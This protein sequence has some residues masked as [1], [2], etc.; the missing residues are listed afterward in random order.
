MSEEV[1][2]STTGL[3]VPRKLLV[4]DVISGLIMAIVTIPGAIANGVL[5][6][7]N[8]VYGLYT[9]MTATPIAALFTSSVIM[10]VDSTS[11]TSLATFDAIGGIPEDEQL[12]YIVVLG[13]LVG[14]F[15]LLFGFLK[16]GFLVRFISNSVMTGF[17]A[18]LGVLTILGQVGDFTGYHSEA[19]NKV[20]QFIDA[21]FHISEW[22]AATAVVG[23]LTIFLILI[24]N[25][26]RLEKFS[27]AIAV[28]LMTM[29][30][31]WLR[32]ETAAIVS[33]ISEIPRSVPMPNL[34]D[35]SLVPAMILPA[36]TIAII[37]LVQAAGV[38]G[39]IP[40]PD[41]DYPDPSGDFRGQGAGN[42]VMG[43]FGGI[44]AG[45]SL[46]GTALIQNI[47]G[48][49]RWA[50][51]F[52]GIFA[53]IA[54][55]LI[56][57]FIEAIPMATLAGLLIVVG[58]GMIKWPRI[59][60]VLHTGQVPMAIMI[61]TF[62]FTLF[63]P[64]QVAVAVGVAVHVMVYI[65]RSAE[66]VR[67]E[68]VLLLEDGTMVEESLPEEL[69]SGE[70]VAILPVGSLFFAGAAEF[71]EHLPEIGDA[72]R[73]VVI[74]GLRDRDE[75]GSTFINI[76]RRYTKQLLAQDNKL[77]LGGMNDKVIEQLARTDLLDLI[78]EENI[79]PV[80][81]QYG[82]ALKKAVVA[83]QQWIDAGSPEGGHESQQENTGYGPH[84]T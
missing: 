79:F 59:E 17:L 81:K 45:G 57:P 60:T 73:R 13:L 49:S 16:L 53:A 9:I 28:V 31:A 69:P 65:Y 70:I 11:A 47:G 67:L 42:F 3:R 75:V 5:A 71:E 36:L 72:H 82:A 44:P 25:R 10:N 48:K 20:F 1:T 30:V 26:T 63:T 12:A 24:I 23:S 18:G 80:E 77:M 43:L 32:P 58:F 78:G 35:L 64:L 61:I 27:F 29:L 55:M 37:A 8:P 19:P 56:A 41:G 46:S 66:A 39:S 4:N 62:I 84:G 54:V 22:D 74:I 68:R 14:L 7:V 2:T 51:V 21:L 83:A 52:T 40:N 50:N 6:G 15:M 38:S 34:P 33:D 76:I